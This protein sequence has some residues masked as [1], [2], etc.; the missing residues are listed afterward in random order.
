MRV[1]STRPLIKADEIKAGSY[2]YAD[3]VL[4]NLQKNLHKMMETVTDNRNELQ[5]Y[6]NNQ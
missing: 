6:N 2:Y 4:E 3:E 5:R 1:L